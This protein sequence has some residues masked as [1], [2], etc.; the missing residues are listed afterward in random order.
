MMA[1]DI[2]AAGDRTQKRKFHKLKL[3][4]VIY[5]NMSLWLTFFLITHST[6]DSWKNE[7]KKKNNHS[8]KND[9]EFSRSSAA[10]GKTN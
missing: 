4:S 7:K 6:N 9:K 3:K 8:Q 1:L 2:Y 10:S 5:V